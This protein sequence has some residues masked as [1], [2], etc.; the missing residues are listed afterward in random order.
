MGFATTLLERRFYLDDLY[1]NGI[2][3]PM[4]GTIADAANWL[5]Q[6]VFDAPPNLAGKGAV[7]AGRAA[8]AV[9]QTLIDGTVNGSGRAS[10]LV[11]RV[12]ALA[13]NGNVQAYATGMFVGVVALAV[14]IAAR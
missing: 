3:R 2:V 13:Q 5:N 4:R 11:G 14:T 1:L 12:L 8:Y 10:A 6:N 7:V 9:D